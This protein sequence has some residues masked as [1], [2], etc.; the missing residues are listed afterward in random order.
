MSY[1]TVQDD[2]SAF[3]TV[4]NPTNDGEQ[5]S[6]SPPASSSSRN[7]WL[8]LAA[9]VC[10]AIVIISAVVLSAAHAAPAGPLPPSQ[11]L[12]LTPVFVLA[13]LHIDLVYQ[14]V[15]GSPFCQPFATA[16]YLPL[17]AYGC[18]A[19][20]S[21]FDS[22]LRVMKT[23]LPCSAD[24][25]CSR[26]AAIVIA[27]DLV[28]HQNINAPQP[29][30]KAGTLQTVN[31]TLAALRHFFPTTPLYLTL[32]NNDVFPDYFDP[33]TSMNATQWRMELA[34]VYQLHNVRF[35]ATSYMQ[36]GYSSQI[37]ALTPTT[38]FKLI[39]LNT[40]IYSPSNPFNFE[41]HNL[42]AD[43]TGQF[44]QLTADLQQAFELKQ[45]PL[46]F[47]HIGPMLSYFQ[48][49]RPNWCAAY[50]HAFER[51]LSEFA[52]AH[53]TAAAP[54]MLF[55]H[56]HEAGFRFLPSTV[57]GVPPFLHLLMSALSP[58]YLNNPN[59][60]VLYFTA[61]GSLADFESYYF[62]LSS[63]DLSDA[64]WQL[65]YIASREYGMTAWNDCAALQSH[66]FDSIFPDR[67]SPVGSPALVDMC[68]FRLSSSTQITRFSGDPQCC[69]K[70]PVL[71]RCLMISDSA[72]AL[73]QCTSI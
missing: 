15:S 13:D 33:G 38:T 19:P 26:A 72:D 23:L 55:A 12:D 9:A 61:D 5:S 59:F 4:L 69:D 37:L 41:C 32:G 39:S 22:A 51:V 57:P 53:P 45:R 65:E 47:G 63:A 73:T 67:R 64:N 30:T 28:R 62:D 35:N 40:V 36:S 50:T 25:S 31:A 14:E 3:D 10:L 46:I 56:Q 58:V 54:H 8:F 60:R 20:L 24:S 42:T 21:L 17:G 2:S 70:C 44:A 52:A 27:G 29:L 1:F 6:L 48:Y 49:G 7:F 18:D 34:S 43:P 71:Q 66:L 68:R 11:R 16:P